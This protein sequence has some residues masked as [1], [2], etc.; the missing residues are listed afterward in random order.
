MAWKI[1]IGDKSMLLDDL[2]PDEL[3]DAC[4]NHPEVN[5]LRMYLTPGMHPGAFYDLVCTV[6]KHLEVPSPDRPQTVKEAAAFLS[7]VQQVDDDLP[8]AFAEGGIPLE[9][10]AE[11][12]TTTSST[13]TAPAAGLPS[14][15]DARP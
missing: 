8:T 10:P 12:A 15:R 9:T 7:H 2:S 6:A 1:T 11:P 5:W 14:K 4:K 13:S 3:V